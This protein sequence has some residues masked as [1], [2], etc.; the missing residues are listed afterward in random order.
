VVGLLAGRTALPA[1]SR[2]VSSANN[3]RQYFHD[4]KQANTMSP[5]ERFMFSLVLTNS[6]APKVAVQDT[7]PLSRT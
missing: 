3:F 6:K 4:L 5:I 2:V 7:V 1:Y